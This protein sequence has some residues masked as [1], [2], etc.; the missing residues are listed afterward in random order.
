MLGASPAKGA[1]FYLALINGKVNKQE[2]RFGTGWT[3]VE[4]GWIPLWC[5]GGGT[6]IYTVGML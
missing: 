5:S 2:G 4:D 1:V 3:P 6:D